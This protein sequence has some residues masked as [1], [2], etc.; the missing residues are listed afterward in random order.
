MGML[1]HRQGEARRK[2]TA[3]K[4]PPGTGEG[5]MRENT[6]TIASVAQETT[7]KSGEA[8]SGRKLPPKPKKP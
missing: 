1:L 3:P 4:P 2:T 6:D 8:T 5:I 7:G